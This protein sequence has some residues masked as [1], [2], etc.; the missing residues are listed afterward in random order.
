MRLAYIGV[1][2]VLVGLGCLVAALC[3]SDWVAQGWLFEAAIMSFTL[4][5]GWASRG[6]AESRRSS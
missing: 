6:L 5:V 2:F 1:G 4:E 3:V